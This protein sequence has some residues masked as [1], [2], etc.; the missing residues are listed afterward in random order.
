MKTA[1]DK[2][3]WSVRA[4]AQPASLQ[5]KLFPAFVVAA[6]ELALEFEENYSPTLSEFRA[7]WSSIQLSKLEALDQKLETMSG[8]EKE[9]LW[10]SSDCLNHSEWSVVRSLAKDALLEFGWPSDQPLPSDAIYVPGKKTGLT[11]R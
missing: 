7:R 1:L 9:D 10:L 2:L 6:D 8:S 5:K 3:I 4:L 11:R